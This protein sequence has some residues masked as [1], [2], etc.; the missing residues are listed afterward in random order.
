MAEIPKSYEPQGVEQQWYDR[1]VAAGCFKGKVDHSRESFAVMIPPPNVT[2]VLHMGHLLNNT[3]QDIMVRR[4]RQE[5]KS[6]LWLP[7]TDHA[8]IATQSRVE[9]ELRQKEGKTRHDLGR[10]KFIQV[11]SE[12][13]DKHGGIILGQLRKLGA[14]CDWDRTV[15]TLDAGYS[16]A[17]LQTFVTLYAR[18]YV[19]RGK[20]MVNWCPVSQ[21]G[22][23]DEEV[24]MKPSK[25]SLYRM[26]Y[27]VAE[28]PGTFLEISTTR[29]ET[30]PGD[31]AVAVHPEDERYKHLIGKHV[32]RPF[33][34]AQ[35]PIVGD[36][37]VEKDFG[38]GV[39]KVTPAHDRTDF[40]IGKRHDLPV[41]DVMNPDGTMNADAGPLAGI[42]RFKARAMAEKL[43]EELGAL[44]KTEP[45]ENTVGYSERADV[46]IEPRLSEQWF[47][48]YPKIDEAKRAVTSGIIKFHPERWTKTYLHWLENIQDWCVSRQLWWGHRIPVWYRKG[49]DRNDPKNLHVSLTAPADAADWEQDND[50]VDTWASSW[51]WCLAT[52]GWR[53]PGETT[54]ELKHWYPTG[55][56]ATG[57]DII[58]LWV[59]RMIIAGLELHGPEKKTL[60][61]DEIRQRIPFKRVYF[62]GIIRDKL[63]R[64]MSKSLGNSP[65]PLDLIAKF[66]ADGLRFGLLSIAPKGQDILFDEDRVGQG[67]N[68]CNKLW[69]A[70]RFRQMSGPM[71]DNSTLAAVVSRIKASQL[72]D[73]D[74]AI[75][76]GLAE[77]TDSTTKNLDEHEFTAYAQGL[78]SFFWGDFCDWY[79]EASKARLR[80]AALVDN[81]L[82]VQDLVL[83]QFLLLLHPV[84]PFI[85]EELW[86]LLGY[87]TENDFIQNHHTGTGGDLLRVLR[88]NGIK[89]SAAK[90][91]DV[92]QLREFVASVR[93]LKSQAN[94]A[95]RR[96]AVITVVA[97]D[98]T[99][100]ALLTANREKLSSL[101]GL[102]E[103]GFADD[104]GDR[105]G[106]LTSLGTVMLEL[107]GTVDVAA[108]K[109]RLAKELAKLEQ[110]V[111]AGEAKLTNEAFVSKAPPKILE[112]ARKQLDESKAKRDEIARMLTTLG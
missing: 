75:L 100:K 31:A 54:E 27:E 104:A 28:L 69:N 90:V 110:A 20:R 94:Q 81:C 3:L 97:K 11:A 52:I 55:A 15:H 82:A 34:R 37:A 63:G 87:G 36:T 49:A 88:E 1:W 2:G 26:R 40:D 96:D 102:A 32:W 92:A 85:S 56:L 33:P 77:L 98:A 109:I 6:A 8:G 73:D 50:V 38:T 10:E 78:Y 95:T 64:K 35:I 29:P 61:D 25:G 60:T 24:I 44:V 46:P 59:A 101:A 74:F 22:L 5:G 17:V 80:D 18:G 13:R 107:S 106:S 99:A 105:T 45:Y 4:A 43:L 108:E 65:E 9:K 83:R 16:Q 53:K 111:A 62:N 112:G 72:D 71:A 66:G 91:A 70:A 39:L 84:A 12:W 51:L 67:R 93:G 14:S 89:L 68:F 79:V 57:P 47:I 76:Q 30:I 86:H 19:Y 23:S 21:T 7:G 103:I 58:F 42:E 41:I 48:R